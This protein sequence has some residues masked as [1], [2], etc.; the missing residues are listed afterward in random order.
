MKTLLSFLTGILLVLPLC[1]SRAQV[2]RDQP[3]VRRDTRPTYSSDKDAE[4]RNVIKINPLSLIAATGS[5]AYERV[6]NERMSGQL[7]LQ[8]TSYSGWVTGGR[9]L[10]GFAVT[11]EFRYFLTG[12]A[13][14]GFF[15]APFLR[16]RQSSITG[17]ITAGG[18]NF[19]GKVDINN[20]GGGVLIGG[21]YILGQRVSI[22]G[23]IGPTINGRSYKFT[24]GTTET[25]YDIPNFFSPVWFRTGFTVGFLF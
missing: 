1:E 17:E 14:K 8:F 5:F 22:E 10:K 20:F 18:R 3:P 9:P 15:L 7:G 13:P 11:P 24:E 19:N 4:Y 6:I 16:Y 23:F 2:R 21:Q 12:S 25:D